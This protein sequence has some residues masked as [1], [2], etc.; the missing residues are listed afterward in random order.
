VIGEVRDGSEQ[1]P[2]VAVGQHGEIAVAWIR[3][4][5]TGQSDLWVK[6]GSLMQG[7]EVATKVENHDPSEVSDPRLNFQ[8]S[9]QILLTW[10]QNSR[11]ANIFN[12]WWA[13]LSKPNET[14]NAQRLDASDST[15]TS[16]LRLAT[17]RTGHAIAVWVEEEVGVAKR[18]KSR[19]YSPDKGWASVETLSPIDQVDA[20]RP[21][22]TYNNLGQAG[23]GWIAGADKTAFTRKYDPLKKLWTAA[24]SL[25]SY[26]DV[27]WIKL[28]LNDRGDLVALWR[29][30]GLIGGELILEATDFS[31]AW[32]NASRPI[33]QSYGEPNVFTET[34]TALALNNQGHRLTV[35]T[36]DFVV[37]QRIDLPLGAIEE[38]RLRLEGVAGH[39]HAILLD[40]GTG[41]TLSSQQ[42]NNETQ[43]VSHTYLDRGVWVKNAPVWQQQSMVQSLAVEADCAGNAAAV[44]T[45]KPAEGQG[46]VWSSVWF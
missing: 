22:V 20:A 30:E 27:S 15:T 40:T 8:P 26:E 23:V 35:W 29:E 25:R 1:S 10:R 12:L 4:D 37:R 38:R 33:D 46:T 13:L 6:R 32:G 7:W 11:T 5:A 41:L 18:I 34:D 3:K 44:W 2:T 21:T 31:N 45:D 39:H 43:I 17:N 28:Q 24:E 36:N 16:E 9:G 19:F 14:V 42:Q